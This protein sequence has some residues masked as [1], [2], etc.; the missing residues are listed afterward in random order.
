ML[1]RTPPG[2][3]GLKLYSAQNCLRNSMS[4]PARGAWI[5]TFCFTADEEEGVSHPARGAWIETL[6]SLTK[7]VT[8]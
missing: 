8:A 6:K 3:R 5:E 7:F 1:S 2:V 4:H